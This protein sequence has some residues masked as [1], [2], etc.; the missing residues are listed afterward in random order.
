M[1]SFYDR[2]MNFKKHQSD[3]CVS[4]QWRDR[5][6]IWSKISSLVF[7]RWTMVLWVWDDMR[8]SI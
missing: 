3:C 1:D 6:H 7:R 8:V 5:N 2:F 4:S